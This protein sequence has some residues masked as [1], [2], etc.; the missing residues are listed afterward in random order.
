[1]SSTGE[2][3]KEKSR[4]AAR[5]TGSSFKN[6]KPS[7]VGYCD[8]SHIKGD[9]PDTPLKEKEVQ[10]E[11][12][13]IQIRGSKNFVEITK[14]HLAQINSTPSGKKLLK[15]IARSKKKVRIVES[16]FGNSVH[17][18]NKPG[19]LKKGKTLEYKDEESNCTD[20]VEGTGE[21]SDCV[22]SYNQTATRAGIE[23]DESWR[24]RPPAIGLAHE[25]I[26]ADDAVHGKTD[27]ELIDGQG[28]WEH[29]AIGLEPYEKKDYTEN[30]I[31]SEWEPKQPRRTGTGSEG[32][33]I[34]SPFG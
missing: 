10:I 20:K 8:Y 12:L 29:R 32:K 6:R 7:P 2:S 24:D 14:S 21:G 9:L 34:S 16:E 11:Y 3:I 33:S 1:M 31:R 25:L 27:T 18:T 23:G 5:N 28:S 22:I 30:K 13:G 4:N 19:A 15:S 17:Y 26:H